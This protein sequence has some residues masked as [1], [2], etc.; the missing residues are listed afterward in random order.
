L[1]IRQKQEY[2]QNLHNEDTNETKK[3]L[4]QQQILLTEHSMAM[5]I[6][7]VIEKGPSTYQR[8]LKEDN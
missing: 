5:Y 7:W 1:L 6:N 3:K 2:I 8:N 4:K